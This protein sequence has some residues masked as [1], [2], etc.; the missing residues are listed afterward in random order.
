[1]LYLRSLK[2]DNGRMTFSEISHMIL[3]FFLKGEK[4]QFLLKIVP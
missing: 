4:N 3:S 2:N 1:M